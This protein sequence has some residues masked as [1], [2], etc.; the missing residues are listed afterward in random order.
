VERIAP[1]ATIVSGVV[2]Y[3]V[4]ID[5]ASAAGALKPDMTANISIRTAERQAVLVPAAAVHG[6]GD[7]RF[8]TLQR[9]GTYVSQP[10][11]V[12]ARAGAFVEVKKG[13]TAGDRVLVAPGPTVSGK[14]GRR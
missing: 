11:A 1:K 5:I 13:V 8:V 4:I 9:G 2:N 7:G 3:E 6:E 12:G 14:D 10:V